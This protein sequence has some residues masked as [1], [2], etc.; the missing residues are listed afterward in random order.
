MCVTESEKKF[1]VEA[2]GNTIDSEGIFTNTPSK[3]NK[4][5]LYSFHHG[6]QPETF[7]RRTYTGKA[8]E[9]LLFPLSSE[10]QEGLNG[11]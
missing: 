9:M 1:L 3:T 2:A 7:K 4:T 8:N 10:G 6:F 11:E 5:K